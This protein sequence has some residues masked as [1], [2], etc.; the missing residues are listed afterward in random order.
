MRKVTL[1]AKRRRRLIGVLTICAL[2]LVATARAAEADSD[3]EPSPD[4]FT[5]SDTCTSR[6]QLRHPERCVSPNGG[7]ELGELAS[8][9][10]YPERPLPTVS[11]D[12]NWGSTDFT[13]LRA[14]G[15]DGTPV[16][17]SLEDAIHERNEF[18]TV[19]PGFVFFS[20]IDRIKQDGATVYM[21]APGVYIR[22]RGISPISIPHFQGLTFSRTPDRPFA[23]V[24]NRVQARSAPGSD[25][26]KTD[27]WFNRY[28]VVWI[29]DVQRVGSWDWYMVGPGMWIE[30]RLIAKLE[31]DPVRPEGVG[32]DR[33]IS[34][35]LYEQT[36]GVYEDGR[37]VYGTLVSSGIGGW[38]TQPGVFQVFEKL[39][40]D[41]MMGAFE[42][43]RSDFYYLEDVP[44]I[45]YYDNDR[46]L[47]GAY[48]HNGFG[49]PRSHGCVNLSM[50]DSHW[51]YEW[52]DEGTWVYVFDPSG[53][54]PTD[55]EV[56]GPGGV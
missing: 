18:R 40:A 36:L 15:G 2:A 54:T 55:A 7:S 41:P 29:Y 20:Y 45:L 56:Y 1:V 6:M 53:K 31:P 16:Y 28:D 23:W 49:Y 34:I 32:E 48:W 43:D 21:I 9:G 51:L 52:A 19:E 3:S 27:H 11:I 37:L 50:A 10:Y 26:P 39:E 22:N 12:G 46:A 17:A 30:Q 42:A 13:Y 8:G 35:N 5:S 24:M 47:H 25:Q 38:W 33:W 4:T 44:W 14:R